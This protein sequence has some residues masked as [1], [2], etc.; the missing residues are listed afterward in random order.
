MEFKKTNRRPQ[1]RPIPRPAERRTLTSI[2]ARPE[3]QPKLSDTDHHNTKKTS[4][5]ES[6]PSS[7]RTINIHIDF[8]VF[9]KI[10]RPTKVGLIAKTKALF[11]S[12]KRIGVVVFAIVIMGTIGITSAV[13]REQRVAEIEN[14][15]NTTDEIIENLEYQTVLPESKS[16]SQLGGWKRVS[17]PDSEPV[18]AYSDKI[19]D[20][21]ISVSQQPLPESFKKGGIDNQVADLAKKFN[22]TTTFDA[23]TTTAYIGTSAKGPQSVI[24]TKNSL[25]ILIK[26]QAKIDDTAWVRYVKSLN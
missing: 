21:P 9:T 2:S 22:A 24:F 1:G 13:T 7:Q 16:I 19:G 20:T 17:P 4:T 23:D 12:R 25:L 11:S 8:G 6:N 3:L 14:T 5:K 15:Q 26:S 10:K 18:Y